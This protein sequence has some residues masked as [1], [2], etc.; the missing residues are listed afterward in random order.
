M[1]R[2]R[3]AASW[4]NRARCRQVARLVEEVPSMT[5]LTPMLSTMMDE[6]LAI[7]QIL[8]RIERLYPAKEVVTQRGQGAPRRATYADVARRTTQLA[9]ALS[10]FGIRQ[11]DRIATFAW[12]TQTHLECYFAIPCMGAVLH[13]VNVRLFEDQLEY[14]VNHAADRIIFCDRSVLPALERL[15]DRIKCVELVVLMNEGP[16]PSGALKNV[17]DYEQFLATGDALYA[18]PSLDERAAAGMCYTSGTT[19]NPKGVIYSHRSTMIHAL[20]AGLPNGLGISERDRVMYAVPMFH[21]NAWGLPYTA[22]LN[23]AAQIMC[24]R[25]MDPEHVFNLLESERVTQSAGVPTIWIGLL[26]LMQRTGRRLPHLRSI[27]SGGSAVPPY[28]ISGYAELGIELVHAWGMTETSPLGSITRLK[29]SMADQ[30]DAE[31][32][33]VLAKQVLVA[34]TVLCRIVDIDSGAEL[35]WD[36]VAFGELQVRGPWVT[37]SYF[38]DPDTADKF[39]DGWLRTGDVAT[40]DPEGY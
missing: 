19:G 35:P 34:P 8:W 1:A 40:I 24:D 14:I 22:A 39:M 3:P 37:S 20:A 17:I 5:A 2:G 6:P 38:H 16:E 23:G 33:T 27:V 10:R 29:A 26:N 30:S 28:L 11:G 15:A 36:G 31:K 21:V 7:S 13:T 18:W 4:Y 25:Y 12:N 32:L 9:S